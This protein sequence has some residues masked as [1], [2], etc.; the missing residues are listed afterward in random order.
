MISLDFRTPRFNRYPGRRLAGGA[1]KIARNLNL[2]LLD[3]MLKEVLHIPC[4]DLFSGLFHT[5]EFNCS[6]KGVPIIGNPFNELDMDLRNL[7]KYLHKRVNMYNSKH[8]WTEDTFRLYPRISKLMLQDSFN[9][10]KA[11]CRQMFD[12]INCNTV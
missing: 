1:R 12:Y 3:G 8:A 4:L 9:L 10:R 2:R 5:V 6:S 7:Q 11:Y